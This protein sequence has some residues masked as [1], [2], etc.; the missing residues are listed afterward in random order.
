MEVIQ[1]IILIVLIFGLLV[2]IHE[3]GHFIAA[4][5][6]GIWVQEFAFGFGPTLVKK[7]FRDTLYKINL[8]PLGGYVKLFGE[9]YLEMDSKVHGEY[10]KLKPKIKEKYLNLV[11]EK[12]LYD[13]VDDNQLKKRIEEL[14]GV[15]SEDMFWLS[16]VAQT[17]QKRVGDKRRFTNKSFRGRLLVVMGGVVMNFLLGV[18]TYFIYLLIVNNI[19]IL[20]KIT[21]FNFLGV[22]QKTI[23]APILTNTQ[24]DLSDLESSIVLSIEGLAEFNPESFGK[25]VIE[26]GKQDVTYFKNGKLNSR[27]FDFSGE[28]DSYYSKGFENKMIVTSIT[29]GSVAEKAGLEIGDVLMSLNEN[30]LSNKELFLEELK[31]NKG[32]TIDLSIYRIG[33]GENIY[34]IELPNPKS[35]EEAI[36][37][38]GYIENEPYGV[39]VYYLKY[40][41]SFIGSV[42]H[43][44]NL[45]GYQI[46]GLGSII[47]DAIVSNDPSIVTETVSG[48]VRVGYEISNLISAKNFI[49]LLNLFGLIS[50]TLALMNILPLPVVDGGYVVLLVLEKLRKRPMSQKSQQIYNL[51]GVSFLILLTIVVTLKD[52]WQ[53]FFE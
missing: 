34:T 27:I 25:L 13:F 7:Q 17:H 22:H 36:L 42:A 39:E 2:G 37:G 29:E 24:G 44:L 20:P 43:S 49:D 30:T 3:F 4:K 19:V 11:D 45:I 14:K 53:V 52:I 6:Q 23:E 28:Y 1:S 47:G 51:I 16:Y 8:I 5:I 48:P 46:K 12:Q 33:E 15:S 35:D 9:E 26:G 32:Q 31:K 18:V 50:L 40:P 10:E 21:E 41:N 38:V